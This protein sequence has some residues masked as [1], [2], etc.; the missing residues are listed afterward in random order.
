MT[1]KRTTRASQS[2]S[3]LLRHAAAEQGLPIDPDGWAA[4]DDVLRLLKMSRAT[5]DH[6][7]ETNAKRRFEVAGARIRASQ[8]HS[9]PSLSLD[10]L[11]ASWRPVP[12]VGMAWHGTS[13]RAALEIAADELRPGERTHV[14]LVPTP[15]SRVGKR[16]AVGLLLGIDLP[17]LAAAGE[18]VFESPNGVWLTRRV[19]VGCITAL[20]STSDAARERL[21]ELRA[22]FRLTP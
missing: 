5:L 2:L 21:A 6:V 15:E 1:D 18:R 10:A 4:I 14:H 9:D 12:M 19:P 11:E 22:A 16:T 20:E 7:V 17:R 3:W 13:V 8:G